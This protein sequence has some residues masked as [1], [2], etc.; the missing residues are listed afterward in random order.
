MIA[1]DVPFGDEVAFGNQAPF[2]HHLGAGGDVTH[3][4]DVIARLA[5]VDAGCRFAGMAPART[6]RGRSFGLEAGVN[7]RRCQLPHHR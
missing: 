3:R 1:D 5:V 6:P 4:A 7:T 2:R